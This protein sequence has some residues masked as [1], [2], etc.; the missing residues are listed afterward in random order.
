MPE[1]TDLQRATGSTRDVVWVPDLVGSILVLLML[2]AAAL[3][4]FSYLHRWT[5]GEVTLSYTSVD[6]MIFHMTG[7]G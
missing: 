4:A 7:L 1:A 6:P 5:L 3:M 2:L